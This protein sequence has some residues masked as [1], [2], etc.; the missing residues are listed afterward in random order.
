M[1]TDELER[2]RDAMRRAIEV[3]IDRGV[4]EVAEEMAT[5]LQEA[6]DGES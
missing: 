4:D 2:L 1:T 5:I 3:Y 6:L